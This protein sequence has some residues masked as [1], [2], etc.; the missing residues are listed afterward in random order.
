[1]K[2]LQWIAEFLVSEHIVHSRGG[3]TVINTETI[4]N[5]SNWIDGE[6]ERERREG[7]VL[8]AIR[9][10]HSELQKKKKEY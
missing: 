2:K 3:T 9:Q 1:M 6:R 5:N 4:N 10:E 8:A 7:K